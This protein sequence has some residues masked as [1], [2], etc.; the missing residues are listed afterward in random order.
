MAIHTISVLFEFSASH[1]LHNPAVSESDNQ[2]MYGKCANKNGHG[3]NYGLEVVLSGPINPT[4]H[5]IFDAALLK[6]IV[7]RSVIADVDHKDLNRDVPWLEGAVPTTEVLA[8]A[9][10]QRL[11]REIA[12]SSTSA[13]LQEITVRE[14]RRISVTVM[15]E[16]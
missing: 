9:I 14:T 10:F 2:R 6:E 12:V 11:A 13:R 15:R 4:T 1:R 5:M 7:E 16:E 3:H 8:N